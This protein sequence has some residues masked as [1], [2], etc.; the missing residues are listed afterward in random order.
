MASCSADRSMAVV[1][2]KMH[3]LHK[4]N[5]I[6]GYDRVDETIESVMLMLNG[7]LKKGRG[8]CRL[9][10]AIIGLVFEDLRFPH[11]VRIGLERIQD[12]LAEPIAGSH[13]DEAINLRTSVA[14]SL[15]P[16]DA[17]NADQLL[18]GAESALRSTRPVINP[19]MLYE[20]RHSADSAD[21]ADNYQLEA[22]LR[23]A[24]TAKKLAIQYQPK[25]YFRDG[26]IAGFEALMRWNHPRRGSVSP[27]LF[28]AIAESA[29]LIGEMTE[30][31]VQ[32]ALR[33][34]ADTAGNGSPGVSVNVSA[35]TLFDPCFPFVIDSAVSMW[36][37][38]YSKLTLEI[39][40]SV[41][42]E[43]FDGALK[44]LNEFRTKGITISIDDFGTGYSSLAYFKHLPADEVKIDRTFVTNMTQC[45]EDLRLVEA[46]ISLS[47]GFNLAVVAEGIE[48]EATYQALKD[49]GCDVA[50]GFY[51]SKAIDAKSIP[52]WHHQ[53]LQ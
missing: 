7:S 52:L 49:L 33:E 31:A 29:G 23:S 12:I 3:D 15:Y 4:L 27:E 1:L 2:V 17:N 43:N 28:I 38:D 45:E 40:E 35:N 37:T 47:H 36:N 53:A 8:L 24:F 22:D 30:W 20:D 48:D 46:I 41:L 9:S 39:T 26:S 18:L 10:S 13:E 25:I 14:A 16:K 21:S 32:T 44:L 19:L 11:L 5:Q 50:Q 42:M 51:I 6:H 34:T